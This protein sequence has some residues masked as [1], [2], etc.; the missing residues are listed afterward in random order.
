MPRKIIINE[1]LI[2]D[3]TWRIPRNIKFRNHKF[4]LQRLRISFRVQM[5]E[6]LEPW[7]W[8]CSHKFLRHEEDK[9]NVRTCKPSK[10]ISYLFTPRAR[11]CV[12][13]RDVKAAVTRSSTGLQYKLSYHCHATAGQVGHASHWVICVQQNVANAIKVFRDAYWLVGNLAGQWSSG[14]T[15]HTCSRFLI[16]SQEQC[17]W[18]QV[19]G[20]AC[21]GLTSS[22]HIEPNRAPSASQKYSW[23]DDLYIPEIDTVE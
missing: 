13:L 2:H 17:S 10:K 9:D 4:T 16:A 3:L 1:V 7:P 22:R 19:A 12:R 6:L 8:T 23:Y 20:W 18:S 11:E 21:C 15:W 14:R 5:D